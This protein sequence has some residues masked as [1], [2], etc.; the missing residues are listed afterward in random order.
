VI[1]LALPVQGGSAVFYMNSAFTD[2]V[3][4][5]FSGVAHS[6]GQGRMKDDLTRYFDAV[7]AQNQ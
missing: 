7:R 1:A 6:V 2:K 4:G 5:F 3:T